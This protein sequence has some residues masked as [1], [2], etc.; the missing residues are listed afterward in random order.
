MRKWIAF[1]LLLLVGAEVF[2][3]GSAPSPPQI[4]RRKGTSD[5]SYIVTN[6]G[7]S[8][9]LR[10]SGTNILLDLRGTHTDLLINDSVTLA[11][12]GVTGT[13]TVVNE[14]MVGDG[15]TGTL[16]INNALAQQSIYSF[17][18]DGMSIVNGYL[19]NVLGQT[20]EGSEVTNQTLTKS[21]IDTTATFPFGALYH[22]TTATSDSAYQS[23]YYI[24]HNLF[25]YSVTGTPTG[26]QVPVYNSGSGQWSFG[27][28]GGGSGDDIAFDM[29]LGSGDYTLGATTYTGGYIN[30]STVWI[31]G[32]TGLNIL[33][34]GQHPGDTMLF[35]PDWARIQRNDGTQSIRTFR[36]TSGDT[37][38]VM[39]DSSSFTKMTTSNN[40]GW[41]F[42]APVHIDNNLTFD[43]S[44]RSIVGPFLIQGQDDALPLA[45]GDSTSLGLQTSYTNKPVV[46]GSS[47]NYIFHADSL[48]GTG[49]GLLSG[50]KRTITDTVVPLRIRQEAGSTFIVTSADTTL[51]IVRDTANDT[52]TLTSV[53]KLKLTADA[54][55]TEMDSVALHGRLRMYDGTNKSRIDSASGISADTLKTLPGG[56]LTLQGATSGRTR[57][58]GNASAITSYD[59]VL[60]A[61][62][63]A[64]NQA[65]INDGS[66]NFSWG[67][68]GT[69]NGSA[70]FDTTTT[71]DSNILKGS[72]GT[73]LLDIH[74]N[75][76]PSVVIGKGTGMTSLIIGG[77]NSGLMSVDT[78]ALIYKTA[79][80]GATVNKQTAIDSTFVYEQ[81]KKLRYYF[82]STDL[83]WSPEKSNAA[84]KRFLT[85]NLCDTA[86][87]WPNNSHLAYLYD[88][89]DSTGDSKRPLN[90]TMFAGER[91]SLFSMVWNY[92]TDSAA[93][94]GSTDTSKIGYP[95]YAILWKNGTQIDSVFI[96]K[97][98]ASLATD[99]INFT[100][101]PIA[102]GDVITVQLWFN[103]KGGTSAKRLRV[104]WA[105]LN[106][107]R[108]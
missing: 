9:F 13:A 54:G 64:A 75:S 34:S 76:T 16:T 66:G 15:S 99:S 74:K 32:D 62:Q 82:K 4:W 42:E 102:A 26:G 22:V 18:G 73:I 78:A 92:R 36:T 24:D 90:H 39:Q 89:V 107:R 86:A 6:T 10:R 25:G 106:M 31:R 104:A 17:T 108:Y 2:A 12:L 49:N 46:I 61:A 105:Y 44:A 81:L 5:T 84:D 33:K 97:G 80:W 3:Q 101:V 56:F 93:F 45:I 65:L 103:S 70:D 87:T 43:N 30:T 98:K 85:W 96:G 60:P 95:E 29:T 57:I 11:S 14:L 38:L 69:G 67:S 63:G 20:I 8:I 58:K 88:L 71:L 72:S 48:Y 19:T 50:L 59:L 55:L 1:V 28:G 91:D 52:T 40:S 21:D 94:T 35:T 53:G 51:K 83:Y 27:S 7:D 100:D 41:K 47:S 37:L 79:Y 23:K 68:A 77:N